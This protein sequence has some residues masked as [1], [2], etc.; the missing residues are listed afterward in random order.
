MTSFRYNS[1]DY[2]VSIIGGVLNTRGLGSN[3][4]NPHSQMV[5][6][7]SATYIPPR[8]IGINAAG[9]YK[10]TSIDSLSTFATVTSADY[11]G[12]FAGNTGVVPIP[13][14]EELTPILVFP[15]IS[16]SIVNAAV[17]TTIGVSSASVAIDN[18]D[19]RHMQ[20]TINLGTTTNGKRRNPQCFRV[21]T[22][23]YER[24]IEPSMNRNGEAYI[25]TILKTTE[26]TS[27][28]NLVLN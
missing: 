15:P 5:T 17:T 23:G 13:L 27:S 26:G 6:I 16:V 22:G 14:D 4:W 10:T 25:F 19:P 2:E 18:S 21:F 20:V 8:I 9:A 11:F 7:V 3:V 28:I 24:S 12:T 1:L